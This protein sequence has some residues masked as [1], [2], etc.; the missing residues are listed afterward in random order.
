MRPIFL[1]GL[2]G[3]GKS[4]LGRALAD[5]GY[6]F[7]D[8]DEAVELRCG[9]TVA[10]VINNHGID[11]FRS[12][13]TE[14]LR[15][16]AASGTR[17]IACG[18]GTPCHS[19][20]MEYMNST[21]ATVLLQCRRDRL[22]RRLGEAG[23]TRPMFAMMEHD[24]DAINR[25]IDEISAIRAPFYSQASATFDSSMLENREEIEETTNKFSEL[26]RTLSADR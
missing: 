19:G 14:E 24:H 16:L 13:E 12:M 22:I 3:C 10:E 1:I 5:K 21:G 2:P 25:K 18:G 17:I 20:N 8:V 11:T 4:T 6:A 26:I 7:A 9:R 23:G 15:R